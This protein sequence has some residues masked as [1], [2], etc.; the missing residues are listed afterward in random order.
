[1]RGINEKQ[2]KQKILGFFAVRMRTAKDHLVTLPCAY[3]RQ[4]TDVVRHGRR[5]VC[6][7]VALPCGIGDGARQRMR[8]NARQRVRMATPRRSAM[9][10]RTA[11]GNGARHSPTHGNGE[12]ARQCQGARQRCNSPRQRYQSTAKAFAV[13]VRHGARQRVR[14]RSRHCRALFAVRPRK[15]KPLPC[16]LAPLPCGDGARQSTV[17]R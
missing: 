1:M 3:A 17:L 15:A 8:P 9:H 16:V 12:G 2:K 14:C 11:K 4:R 7:L 13:R 10:A 5:L 6:C